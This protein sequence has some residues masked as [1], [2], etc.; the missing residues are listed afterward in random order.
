MN[1][2]QEFLL[3]V[4]QNE[5]RLKKNLRKNI[6]YD[7]EIFDEIW[8]ET[9]LKCHDNILKTGKNI[10]NLENWFYICC[11]WNY[12]TRQNQYRRRQHTHLSIDEVA[13]D[14]KEFV[15][16]TDY[17][18][19]DESVNEL[20]SLI[21]ELNRNFGKRSTELFIDY[22]TAK[23]TGRSSYQQIADEWNIDSAEVSSTIAKMKRFIDDKYN[24]KTNTLF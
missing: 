3:F 18:N 20:S 22:F 15:N 21:D 1:D 19:E 2:A 6:T 7:K 5:K 14:R 11:K 12:I 17:E 24:Y 23:S 16:E 13:E 4:S 8:T 10:E 9:I